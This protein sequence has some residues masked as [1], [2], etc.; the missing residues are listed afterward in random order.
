MVIV[1]RLSKVQNKLPKK[2]KK[3]K[4]IRLL[5]TRDIYNLHYV[6]V[7]TSQQANAIF[8]SNNLLL[9]IVLLTTESFAR[10]SL[11][12]FFYFINLCQQKFPF[13]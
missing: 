9:K 5:S 4:E 1:S 13:L 6:S 10:N 2:N 12:Y 11:P 8:K 7:S 3:P